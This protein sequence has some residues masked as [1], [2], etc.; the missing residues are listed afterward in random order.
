ME[1]K[2]S[3]DKDNLFERLLDPAFIE[4]FRK[5][6]NSSPI[7]LYD[8]KYMSRYN[9]SCAV[10]DRLETCVEKLNTYGNYPDSE[11]DFL[12][13][14]MFASMATE[15]VKEMLDKLGVR[16]K[17]EPIY[18]SAEDYCFF[19]EAYI[20][21]QI[22]NPDA[23]IP[24]DDEFFEYFRSL[25]FAH[26]AETNHQKFKRPDEVQYSPWV[27]VNR[28]VVGLKGCKYIVGVRIYT[29]LK[30]DIIDLR[31]PFSALKEYVRS[32]YERIS[33]A[34]M[35]A[36]EQIKNVKVQWRKTKISRE[37][38]PI[39]ILREVNKTLVARF[40]HAY[41]VKEAIRYLE[42]DLTDESNQ[43][44]V[45]KYRNAI[46]EQI[47][48]LCDAV[49]NLDH[50]L[51]EELCYELYKRPKK[52]HPMAS[53][54]LEKIFSYLGDN[55][56]ANASSDVIYGLQQTKYFSEGFAKKWV[57]I[58]VNSMSHTEIQ[59]LVRTACYLE[60]KEQESVNG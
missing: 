54:Q 37:Q 6:I 58:N 47:P 33:L 50:E 27:I 15:T 12:V 46:V 13:F 9:L 56:S 29:S 40:E 18:N 17:K 44:T 16:K 55:H 42:C 14:M 22:Y 5:A 20:N 24:T 1:V 57:K 4:N 8:P 31:V 28:D 19:S 45:A 32:R 23:K 34:T 39:D 10:I 48:A 38:A 3:D 2:L 49:D 60:R 53:Y 59:L 21:S 11:E 36:L 43:S 41:S 52:M 25:S 26:P 30:N 35:W 51:A 7:F